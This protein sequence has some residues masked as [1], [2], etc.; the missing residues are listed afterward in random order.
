[1]VMDQVEITWL[2]QLLAQCSWVKVAHSYDP[3]EIIVQTMDGQFW[4][5]TSPL[6]Y[7]RLVY[8]YECSENE[9]A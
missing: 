3:G 5:L 1:M 4:T 8:Q 7:V 6:A 2:I 9:E